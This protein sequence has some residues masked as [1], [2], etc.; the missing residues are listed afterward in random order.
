VVYLLEWII[1]GIISIFTG[2]KVRTYM[3]ISFEQ[4]AYINDINYTYQE[5]RKRWAWSKYIF[6]LVYKNGK[7]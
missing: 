7:S 5:S 1:K 6:K 2:F 4:E 3:S